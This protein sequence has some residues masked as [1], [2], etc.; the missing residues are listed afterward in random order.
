MPVTAYP[1]LGKSKSATLCGAFL[2]GYRAAGGTENCAV[3]YG[4]D[5]SNMRKWSEVKAFGMPWYAIDNSYFDAVRGEQFRIAKSRMQTDVEGQE[6][7][8]KRFAALGL[9]V[10]SWREE[11]EH[12]VVC[13][14]SE[15]FMREIVG[16]KGDWLKDA[17][18]ILGYHRPVLVR[19]WNRDKKAQSSTLFTDLLG[20]WGLVTHSSAAAVEALLEGVMVSVSPMS[21]CFNQAQN[22]NHLF[23][24]LADN[25]WTL[26]EIRNGDAWRWLNR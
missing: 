23:G 9:H 20:A 6:T 4:V 24:V 17:L 5:A 19:G 13:P 16:Y 1:V 11:G 14:Q 15:S 7:D 12:W 25:Q 8:G 26:D 2:D 10:K 18:Q 21:A 22:R 3:F